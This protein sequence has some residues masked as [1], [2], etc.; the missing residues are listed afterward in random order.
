MTARL[1]AMSNTAAVAA[2]LAAA[3]DVTAATRLM[4]CG[5][6]TERKRTARA[7]AVG[8]SCTF[9]RSR[10]VGQA[11][12]TLGAAVR[13]MTGGVTDDGVFAV[14]MLHGALVM[15]LVAVLCLK[16]GFHYRFPLGR[17]LLVVELP[18]GFKSC[19]D[20][21]GVIG[22]FKF[23]RA[24]VAAGFQTVQLGV[25]HHLA[26]VCLRHV[27][28][29]GCFA[30]DPFFELV[31]MADIDLPLHKGLPCIGVNGLTFGVVWNDDAVFGGLAR[32]HPAKSCHEIHLFLK[33]GRF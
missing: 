4:G 2:G 23:V 11:A 31:V 29:F 3:D 26:V 18:D 14:G 28:S 7:F 20:L 1:A 30:H 33:D 16:T 15:R 8:G 22:T 19:M 17:A 24:V 9:V 32:G 13:G 25:I 10:D 27:D 6:G 21:L 5:N 12:G